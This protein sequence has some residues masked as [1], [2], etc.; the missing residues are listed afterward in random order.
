LSAD[1]NPKDITFRAVWWH[2]ICKQCHWPE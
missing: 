2:G 1:I